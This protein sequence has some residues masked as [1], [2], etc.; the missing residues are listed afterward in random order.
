MDS[1][2]WRTLRGALYYVLPL[3]LFGVNRQE[4]HMNERNDERAVL[5]LGLN[6]G[7]WD[8]MTS[9]DEVIEIARLADELGQ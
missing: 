5:P 2:G 3:S 1:N 6:L 9:W 4:F 7:I 8:R